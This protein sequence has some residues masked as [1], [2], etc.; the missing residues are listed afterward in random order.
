MSF[1]WPV[2]KLAVINSALALCGDTGIGVADDGSEEWTVCSPAY[3]RA[4]GFCMEGHSWGYATQ[5]VAL[6]PSPTPPQDSNWDTAFVL[7]ST[8]VHI[9]WAK[10]NNVVPET[11]FNQM[12]ALFLYDIAGTP[13]GPVLVCNAQGGPPPPNP[14]VP[15][16][17][18]TLKGI[19]NI[20]AMTDSTSG[21][22]TLINALM[23]FVES[24]IY[25]GLHEDPTEAKERE[26][27][28]EYILQ[29]ARTRYDQQKPKRQFFNSRMT[30]ARRIRRPWPPVG[31]NSW[32]GSGIPG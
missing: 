22:P 8:L 32:G 20:D 15:P 4:L 1:P 19:F 25:R 18:V 30:A 27:A 5:V 24:A 16:A 7:P 3:D 13:N 29:L 6:Q 23:T 14:A 31:N 9:V 26:K 11:P 10:I 28:A 21:T 17:Q 12:A 2:D